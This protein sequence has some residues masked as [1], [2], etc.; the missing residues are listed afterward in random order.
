MKIEIEVES[1]PEGFKP[2]SFGVLPEGKHFVLAQDGNAVELEGPT[3]FQHLLLEKLLDPCVAPEANNYYRLRNGE[4]VFVVADDDTG[5]SSADGHRSFQK[6]G[7]NI[8]HSCRDLVE[9]L[10]PINF[11]TDHL[12][13]CLF[14]DNGRK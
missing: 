9:K 2:K 12:K 5:F 10:D 4:T 7:K 3:L 14:S 1:I 11:P 13:E 8:L 6:S